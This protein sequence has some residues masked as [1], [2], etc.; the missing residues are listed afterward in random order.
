MTSHSATAGSHKTGAQAASFVES[1]TWGKLLMWLFLCSDA[2][3]FGGLI[4]AFFAYRHL[5]HNWPDPSENLGLILT[6][7][8]TFILIVSSFTMVKALEAVQKGNIKTLCNMLLATVLGGVVFLGCQ[9]YEWNHLIQHGGSAPKNLFWATF[10]VMT[11]FHGMHVTG[12]VIYNLAIY[13]RALKGK[14]SAENYNQVEIAGL[15][16]H[17]VDLVWILIFTFVYLI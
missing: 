10:F 8:M 1:L 3:S 17:F 7:G 5:D 15:Y 13:L 4:A 12:G 9:A 6:A 11:G 16:W 14:Y 2:M